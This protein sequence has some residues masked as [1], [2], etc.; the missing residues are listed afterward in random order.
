[1]SAS[2]N[3]PFSFSVPLGNHYLQAVVLPK[4]TVK[5]AI[6]GKD[7]LR[8][9]WRKLSEFAQRDDSDTDRRPDYPCQR[10]RFSPRGL[11]P[12]RRKLGGLRHLLRSFLCKQRASLLSVD[13]HYEHVN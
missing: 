9:R 3:I 6:N 11:I 8:H 10:P 12:G 7:E 4:C 13:C 1:M 5:N 2:F